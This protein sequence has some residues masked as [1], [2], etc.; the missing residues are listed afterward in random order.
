MYTLFICAYLVS[1]L[2]GIG[3]ALRSG[4]EI[5]VMYLISSFVNS[6]FLGLALSLLW[7]N[8]FSENQFFLVGLCVLAGLGGTATIDMFLEFFKADR[9]GG[10]F[11]ILFK[12]RDNNG[13]PGV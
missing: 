6:G 9:I 10:I 8:Y 12:G 3:A 4:R 5:T 11:S 1:G 13:K 2:A 7:Y